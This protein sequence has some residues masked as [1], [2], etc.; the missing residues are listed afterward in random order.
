MKLDPWNAE[1]VPFDS[2]IGL[3]R[4]CAHEVDVFLDSY[5]EHVFYAVSRGSEQL[6]ISE[7]Y[8][9]KSAAVLQIKKVAERELSRG[10]PLGPCAMF[11]ELLRARVGFCGPGGLVTEG[12]LTRDDY[13]AIVERLDADLASNR[14]AAEAKTPA[15]I[16][17]ARE[18]GLSPSA[19]GT[20][21][22]HWS[23][24]CPGTGHTLMIGGDSETFGCGYCRR[25]GDA[26]E[27][28][29]FVAERRKLR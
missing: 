3:E 18:L 23:A 7:P 9:L 11:D 28:R 27:L 20:G 17:V 4:V 26:E 1:V 2:S 12:L 6:W 21:S 19:L 29:R 14:E 13:E 24:N 15:I 5:E 8:A 10:I 25:K 22:D 16:E